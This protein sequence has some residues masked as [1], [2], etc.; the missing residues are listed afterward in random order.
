MLAPL[1]AESYWPAEASEPI[2]ETTVGS[3]LRTAAERASDVTALIEG[4]PD[5]AARR[6]WTNADLLRDSEVVAR[7]LLGRFGPGERIAVWANNIPEWVVLEFGAALAG[8]TLVTVNPAYR[9]SELSYILKQ[10]RASGIFLLSEYRGNPMAATLEQ[11]RP[12]LRELREVVLFS[13]WTAFC[14]SGAATERLPVVQPG[15]AAQIQYTSGTTGFP[16]G[17]VLHHRGITNNARLFAE[18]LAIAPGDVWV[19][20]MPMF[21]TAGCVLFTLG[22]LQH[23]ATQVLMPFFD[24]ALQLALIESERGTLLGGVPTMLIAM[25]EHPEYARRDLSSLR[26]AMAG[27]ATVPPEVVR[28]IEATLHIPFSITFA[29]TEASPC[30][31]QTRLNDSHEDRAA[32]LGQPLPQTKVKIVDPRTGEIVA[33]GVVGE[34][35]TRGYHVMRGYFENP[36][37][38]AATIDADGWLH[39]GDLCSMDSRGFCYIEGRLTEMIIRGGENIYP[40]EIEQL[41]FSHPAVADVAVVGLPDPKWG[42]QVAAFIRPAA[43]CKPTAEELFNFCRE[44]LASY[45]TPRYW[46]FVERFPMTASG[47]VQKF[48]LRDTFVARAAEQASRATPVGAG[49]S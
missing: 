9:S 33:P 43:G 17:A 15:D 29:Q 36:Q 19:N 22:P 10:S 47:K 13:D 31:T 44:H 25:L 35:C 42:E 5:Q 39:T 11:S 7:A 40:R 28:R 1:L 49:P 32:S 16:K 18:R 30:I 34:L 3:I 21:H 24:A 45:K 2:L 37:A 41:L 26:C 12:H 46:E 48:V 27:G 14:A 4:L 6:H 23:G 38:T 8:M 20:P